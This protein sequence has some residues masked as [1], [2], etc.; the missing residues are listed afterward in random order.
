M[1]IFYLCKNKNLRIN[2]IGSSKV[3][4]TLNMQLLSLKT[5]YKCSKKLIMIAVN[6]YLLCA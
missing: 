3:L 2:T 1:K 6:P 5:M 4:T